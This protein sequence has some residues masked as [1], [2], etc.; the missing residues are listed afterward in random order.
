MLDVGLLTAKGRLSPKVL[1]EGNKIFEEFKGALT[2]QYVAQELVAAG[3]QLYYYSTENS[4]GEIDFVVQHETYCI[5]VEVK[6]VENLRARSLRA[7]K[8]KYQPEIAIRSSMSN[9]REQ[10]WMTNVPL[11]MLVNYLKNVE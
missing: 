6:A 8:E 11:F 9:Y 3:Y 4:S 2:E 1:L 10:K 5:P 7:F